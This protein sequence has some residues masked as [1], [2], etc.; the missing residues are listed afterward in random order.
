MSSADL[1]SA[2]WYVESPREQAHKLFIGR[3]INR[4]RS[5]PYTQRTIVLPHNLAA[6]AT[7]HHLYLKNYANAGF[8]VGDHCREMPAPVPSRSEF[9]R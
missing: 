1:N 5:N 2:S 4:R 7:G 3:A 6:R 9:Q 8:G